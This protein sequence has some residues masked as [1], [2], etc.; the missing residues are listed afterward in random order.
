VKNCGK[1]EKKKIVI[2]IS[3]MTGSGKSTV[4][5]KLAEKYGLSYFSGGDALRILAQE[6]GYESEV[7][8]WWESTEGLNFLK[9]RMG[10][11]AFD[12]K[13]DEK[14]LELA[15]E[16]N[17]VMDSWTIP[18]LL[19]EGFK[20][21]LDASPKVRV[22]RVVT[23]DS[24]SAEKALKALTEK[25]ERTRQI[26]K[27]LY[28]FDLGDDLTPF[29]LVLSTDELDPD[30]VFYAVSLVTDRLVFSET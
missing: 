6:E 16:G 13:I 11:P 12:K 30:D 4:A 1:N 15:A 2:C 22:E 5:K 28:G 9:Q 14:L 19:K 23:R 21:W 18:W 29:N 26:Y 24:I 25:D 17:V 10:D 3:G 20:V 7:R 8:G 27:S